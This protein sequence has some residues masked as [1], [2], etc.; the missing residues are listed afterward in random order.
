MQVNPFLI[1]I[2]LILAA[3]FHSIGFT[4]PAVA[5]ATAMVTVEMH[6]KNVLDAPKIDRDDCPRGW[7]FNRSQCRKI[8]KN[9]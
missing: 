1:S 2:G 8:L 4:T 6:Q 7:K 5:T 3:N 9:F